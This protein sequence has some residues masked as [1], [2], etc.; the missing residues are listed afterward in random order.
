M[1]TNRR[2]PLRFSLTVVYDKWK[3]A[4][5]DPRYMLSASSRSFHSFLHANERQ[6]DDSANH[7]ALS[8]SLLDLGIDRTPEKVKSR[9]HFSHN[10]C[11]SPPKRPSS[12][13][14]KRL[15]P[16]GSPFSIDSIPRSPAL[17]WILILYLVHSVSRPLSSFDGFNI[18]GLNP[19]FTCFLCTASRACKELPPAQR[20]WPH[21]CCILPSKKRFE[22]EFDPGAAASRQK[23]FQGK[24]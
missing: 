21:A 3:R 19:D 4:T 15:K 24:S 14:R 20:P 9:L 17:Q 7:F 16:C 18:A 2:S 23:Q 11:A 10:S 13:R 5:A 22:S 8:K 12:Q 6:L 1:R